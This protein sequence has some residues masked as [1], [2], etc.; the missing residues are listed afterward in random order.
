[1]PLAARADHRLE[2][3]LGG[4]RCQ[5]QGKRHGNMEENRQNGEQPARLKA[6][7]I[8]LSKCC[9][10]PHGGNITPLCRVRPS[11]CSAQFV[12][13]LA[14]LPILAAKSGHSATKGGANG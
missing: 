5:L 12:A 14:L 9:Q 13:A 8:F 2:K 4:R 11:P 1:L 3:G 7:L 10:R 6:A